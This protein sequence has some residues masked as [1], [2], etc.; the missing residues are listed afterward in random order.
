MDL[1]VA[2]ALD[3]EVEILRRHLSHPCEYLVTGMGRRRTQENLELYFRS[4]KPSLFLFTGTAGQL[5]PALE[6]GR[7]FFPQTWCLE[8]GP[9]FEADGGWVEGLRR[10][11]WE[12]SGRGLTV[13]F[14][15]ARKKARFELYRKHGASICDMEGAVALKVATAFRI[16]ALAPKVISDTAESA[17]VAFWTYFDANML[18]LAAYLNRLLGD[19]TA[20]APGRPH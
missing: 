19:L 9:C 3:K 14:P 6:M 13:R 20:P 12:I 8:E 1:L 18:K 10:Q 7:V 11:G 5:D 15:V 4:R 2:C 17:L 16:P